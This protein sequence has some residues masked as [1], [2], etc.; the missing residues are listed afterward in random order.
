MYG[1]VHAIE[2]YH[3]IVN[4]EQSYNEI[5]KGMIS[6]ESYA[7]EWIKILNSRILGNEQH[8]NQYNKIVSEASTDIKLFIIE[9][10]N[11]I[12]QQVDDVIISNKINNFIL[13]L[14]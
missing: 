7:K 11:E 14:K 13:N 9:I 1:L 2:A 12:K 8:L 4:L 10:M 5:L 3:K 6:S